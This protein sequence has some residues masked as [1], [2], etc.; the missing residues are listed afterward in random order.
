LLWI[1]VMSNA[2]TGR[3]AEGSTYSFVLISSSQLFFF[4]G[5]I[6]HGFVLAEAQEAQFSILPNHSP[7]LALYPTS[8]SEIAGLVSRFWGWD[9]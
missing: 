7:C 4:F 1:A 3:R 8:H 9:L 2:V 6:I 5:P